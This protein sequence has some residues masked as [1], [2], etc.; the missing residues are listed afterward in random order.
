MDLNG[1]NKHEETTT[2]LGLMKLKCSVQNYDWGR[3]GYES[4]V[5]KLFESNSGGEIDE[6]KH[7]AEFWMGTHVSGPS[8]LDGGN[9]S[10]KSWLMQNPKVLGDVVVNKWGHD[11]P[12][13]L[14]V[15]YYCTSSRVMRRR[16]PSNKIC[17]DD[18]LELLFRVA[19]SHIFV[20]KV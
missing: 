13:L 4:S 18:Y 15:I 3:V 14:K 17:G 2:P 8:F 5:A 9:V 12:F 7:Y 16:V 19:G 11:L 6:K 10:L 20:L 1:H